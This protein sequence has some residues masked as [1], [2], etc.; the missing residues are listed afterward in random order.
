MDEYLPEPKIPEWIQ[1]EYNGVEKWVL[2]CVVEGKD[3]EVCENVEMWSSSKPG[4]YGKGF[5]NSNDDPFRVERTG[6]LGE[7]ALA[8]IIELPVDFKYT[9]FGDLTDFSITPQATIDVK[10][11]TRL[12]D[13]CASLITAINSNGKQ[14]QLKS[15]YYVAAY[16]NH[17]DRVAKRAEV[18][19]VGAISAKDIKRLPIK[20]A[21]R[22]G[23]TNKNYELEYNN[24]KLDP[25]NIRTLVEFNGKQKGSK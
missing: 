1:C 21:R 23:A 19:I 9:E 22:Q 5:A 13:Y 25:E 2:K 14:I 20:P 11:A 12:S 10:T 18:I 15:Q 3:Y 4:E 6:K 17:D 24:P 8:Q 7:M 16:I